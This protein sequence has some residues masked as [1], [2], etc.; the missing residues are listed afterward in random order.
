VRVRYLHSDVETVERSEIIRDLRLG[1]FDVLVGINL[2]REGLDMPEVALVAILDADKE[3][4]LRSENS[5]IQTIGRAARNLNGRAILYADRITGSMQ[6]AMGETDRRRA[7]ADRVQHAARHHAARHRQGVS[8]VMEGARSEVP[9]SDRKK[10][11]QGAGARGAGPERPSTTNVSAAGAD[12]AADQAGWRRRCS[13]RPATS[14][15]RLPPGCG[16]RSRSLKRAELGS[17]RNADRLGSGRVPSR[18]C[19]S[20]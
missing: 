7:Q 9:G 1:K 20:R 8:D 12:R 19:L 16:T 10:R 15:S 18:V 13:A 2:L 11:G 3:G 6:R 14:N 17:V 5:L 4:F